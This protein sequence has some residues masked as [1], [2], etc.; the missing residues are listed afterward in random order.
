[1]SNKELTFLFVLLS[2]F[3]GEVNPNDYIQIERLKKK[4]ERKIKENNLSY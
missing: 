3:Q 4:I 1:M 2:H